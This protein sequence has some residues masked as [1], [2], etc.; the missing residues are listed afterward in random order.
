MSRR[1]VCTLGKTGLGN[2][3]DE[4]YHSLSVRKGISVEREE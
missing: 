2:G 3:A 1:D 4:R